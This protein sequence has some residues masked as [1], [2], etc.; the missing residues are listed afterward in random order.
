MLLGEINKPFYSDDYLFEI[1]F[2]GRDT[3]QITFPS[4]RNSTAYYSSKLPLFFPK[5]PGTL[6]HVHASSCKYVTE[7][8]F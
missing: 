2:D 8:I 1:K 3:R 6:L 7:F 5:Q 4:C